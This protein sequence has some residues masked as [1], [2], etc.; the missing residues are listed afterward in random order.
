[1]NLIERV[2]ALNEQSNKINEERTKNLGRYDALQK[3]LNATIADYNTRYGTS[4]TEETIYTEQQKVAEETEKQIAHIESILACISA[5]DYDGANKLAG[6]VEPVK[7]VAPSVEVASPTTAPSVEPVT[8]PSV[9]VVAPT[10][11]PTKDTVVS[12][13]M[14]I[15]E[16]EQTT[17]LAPP[18]VA[19]P[20]VVTKPMS[21]NSIINGTPFGG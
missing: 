10:T 12:V 3:Q 15:F 13:P 21:F 6:V 2:K 14:Q 17:P 16:Q 7:G 11:A 18:P 9:E 1:M 19:P 5:G 20:P 8:A 4:L